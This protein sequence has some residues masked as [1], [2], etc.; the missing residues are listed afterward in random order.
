MG[1]LQAT[2]RVDV[3]RHYFPRFLVEEAR[4]GHAIDGLRVDDDVVKHRQGYHHPL[5]RPQALRFL[6]DFAGADHVLF[7][8]D[9]PFDMTDPDQDRAIDDLPEDVS[10][11]VWGENA[12]ELLGL[13]ARS[14]A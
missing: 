9:L 2:Q 11:R 14:F 12:V 1:S 6:V 7:G 3:H 5:E 8:T 10:R 4:R 13:P